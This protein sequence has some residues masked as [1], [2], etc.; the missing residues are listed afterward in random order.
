VV[1]I[2]LSNILKR[3]EVSSNA[4]FQIESLLQRGE[5]EMF[6][7]VSTYLA[8]IG[9]EDAIIALHEDWQRRQAPMIGNY[10][11]WEVLSKVEAPREFIAIARYESEELAKVAESNL[12]RDAWFCRMK[13]LIEEG[14]IHTYWTVAWQLRD[15]EI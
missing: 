13:S 11:S 1:K 4:S 15:K 6:V 3:P 10:L 12:E 14:P 9:E 5:V 7:V 8:K 2:I